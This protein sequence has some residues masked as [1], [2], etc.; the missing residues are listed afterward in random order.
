MNDI[1]NFKENKYF[2]E[3]KDFHIPFCVQPDYNVGG[4]CFIYMHQ[5]C[6]TKWQ[7]YSNCK[8]YSV[9]LL[10]FAGLASHSFTSFGAARHLCK[11]AVM[12]WEDKK[13]K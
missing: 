11:V 13:G 4:V 9:L 7:M 2:H 6:D 8:S 10:L 5:L 12:D 1:E 3:K